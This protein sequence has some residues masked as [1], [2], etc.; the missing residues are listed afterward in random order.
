MCQPALAKLFQQKSPVNGAFLLELANLPF[1]DDARRR[2]GLIMQELLCSIVDLTYHYTDHE[3]VQGRQG[4][5]T[6]D[7]NNGVERRKI[8]AL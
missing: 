5:D 3:L 8:G 4:I 7:F 1:E 6:D 2:K